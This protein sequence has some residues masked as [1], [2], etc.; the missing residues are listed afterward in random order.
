MADFLITEA[1]GEDDV[2]VGIDEGNI[3]DENNDIE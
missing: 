2:G 3:F 1:V